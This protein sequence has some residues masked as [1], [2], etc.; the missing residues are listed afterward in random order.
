M[1]WRAHDV[2]YWVDFSRVGAPRRAIDAA[3]GMDVARAR[4]AGADAIYE[5]KTSAI[6]RY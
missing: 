3:S 1:A 2:D 4:G 5:E 6:A